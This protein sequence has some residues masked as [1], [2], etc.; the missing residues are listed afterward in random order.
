MSN[1]SSP[2]SSQVVGTTLGC[3]GRSKSLI[4]PPL[5]IPSE[6]SSFI[7]AGSE[8]NLSVGNKIIRSRSADRAVQVDCT[9]EEPNDNE[10]IFL[11]P[12]FHRSTT[13]S[14][15]PMKRTTHSRIKHICSSRE[16]DDRAAVRFLGDVIQKHAAEQISSKLLECKQPFMLKVQKNLATNSPLAPDSTSINKDEST[17]SEIDFDG[18]TKAALAKA[19]ASLM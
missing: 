3:Q 14:A 1:N 12:R 19:I 5:H 4:P 13:L 11:L 17:M 10:R 7:A 9:N 15:F 16:A 18:V 8:S 6:I 2:A